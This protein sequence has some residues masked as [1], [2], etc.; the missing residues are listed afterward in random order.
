M[1]LKFR[2][3]LN[4][5]K[6]IVEKSGLQGEWKQIDGHQHQFRT[7]DDA[8]LNWWDSTGTIS[9]QGN[10]PAK[11][12]LEVRIGS[13]L[14]PRGGPAESAATGQ[15]EQRIFVVHGHDTGARDQLELVL[16]RMDL[17]PFV[18][19]NNPGQGRTII[20]ALEH[21]IGKEGRAGFGIVLLTPDDRG[22]SKVAG[23]KEI[24]DRPRQNV[25]LEMGM[26][27]GSLTRKRVAVLVKGAI[28]WPSDIGGII[29]IEFND[30]VKDT[31]P[32][33]AQELQAAGFNIS[34]NHIAA[35]QQ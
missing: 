23:E 22:Y 14:N 2:G 1:A 27:F 15:Q 21:E 32:K 28:E 20:E 9:F 10:K 33:L 25:I 16:R 8:V 3:S 24:K 7:A 6:A 29:R 18:L 19:A 12:D 34:A 17:E 4:E 5:L 35:A 13:L 31:V 26:L 30:S 11:A